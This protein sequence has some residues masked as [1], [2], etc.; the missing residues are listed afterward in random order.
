[1]SQT[2][3]AVAP[4][5]TSLNMP[6]FPLPYFCSHHLP[7]LLHRR[8]MLYY[9]ASLTRA[10]LRPAGNG[11]LVRPHLSYLQHRPLLLPST[12][13]TGHSSGPGWIIG[14]TFLKNVYSAFRAPLALRDSWQ[15]HELGHTKW[16]T[17]SHD[18]VCEC[19]PGSGQ[20][21]CGVIQRDP[22]PRFAII[23]D[24]QFSLFTY[25]KGFSP[26]ES[27]RTDIGIYCNTYS[28]SCFVYAIFCRRS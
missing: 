28:L 10:L 20:S 27:G 16:D 25:F 17:D 15:A 14:D 19:E 1:M 9:F 18:R 7:Q 11:H 5:Q 26:A 6:G 3:R 24:E 23:C 22:S 2:P 8:R 13:F 21:E 12:L 4:A